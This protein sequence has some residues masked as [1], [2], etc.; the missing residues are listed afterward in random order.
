[1]GL[2]FPGGSFARVGVAARASAAGAAARFGALSRGIA[3]FDEFLG[4]YPIE[5][6]VGFRDFFRRYLFLFLLFLFLGFVFLEGRRGG[7][8][9][10]V[11][12]WVT[13]TFTVDLEK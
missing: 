8:L 4:D 13:S 2:F 10:R 12:G 7:A 6:G 9:D 11:L 3:D 5:S 1:M